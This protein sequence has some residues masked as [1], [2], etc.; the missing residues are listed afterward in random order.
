MRSFPP[1]LVHSKPITKATKS[2]G[3][4][5]KAVSLDDRDGSSSADLV[6]T[7]VEEGRVGTIRNVLITV[8]KEP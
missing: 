4:L 2:K 3:G 6:G 5:K 7:V 1:N 8:L